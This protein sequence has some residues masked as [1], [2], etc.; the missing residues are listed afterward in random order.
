MKV[1]VSR[2]RFLNA[3]NVCVQ[4]VPR[5][6]IMP[7]LRNFHLAADDG[8][9]VVMANDEE[10]GLRVSFDAAAVESSGVALVHAVT[11]TTALRESRDDELSLS[12]SLKSENRMRFRGARFSLDLPSH[13]S[14]GTYPVW[15][16]V[17]A[18]PCSVY[19]APLAK[20]IVRAVEAASQKA[21]HYTTNGVMLDFSEPGKVVVVATDS[22]RMAISSVAV[23]G[24]APSFSPI[25]PRKS[26]DALA[27]VLGKADGLVQL[28]VTEANFLATVGDVDV[29]SRLIT[30]R[31]PNYQGVLK[32]YA[33]KYFLSL[34]ARELEQVVRQGS[35]AA[36]SGA[37]PSR[38]RLRVQPAQG[39]AGAVLSVEAASSEGE[40]QATMVVASDAVPLEVFLNPVFLLRAVASVGKSD[41]EL[42]VAY[43]DGKAPFYVIDGDYSH[44]VMPMA[45][46]E[47][48][49]PEE[50]EEEGVLV[51]AEE[52][53][54]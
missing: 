13:P 10:L 19:A 28:R 22:H 31:Y 53:D 16:N 43:S 18:E 34:A 5:K 52:D 15:T 27:A 49:P 30:G 17:A 11:L 3:C 21:T 32:G 37:E 41:G 50:D 1:T 47:E 40:S 38:S 42:T 36:G 12:P 23:E 45:E 35:V 54:I 2:A 26:A 48:L 6:E 29:Y 39:E 20:A 7:I 44:L 51:D 9:L 33:P 46:V 8:R 14:P 4:A 24:V 25:L